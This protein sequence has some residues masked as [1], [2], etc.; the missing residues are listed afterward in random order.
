[1]TEKLDLSLP[2]S[3]KH[4]VCCILK[5]RQQMQ[6]YT[7]EEVSCTDVPGMKA[8]VAVQSSPFQIEV[9]RSRRWGY[10]GKK[11]YRVRL[12]VLNEQGVTISWVRFVENLH[13]VRQ[14]FNIPEDSAVWHIRFSSEEETPVSTW[15]PFLF[16]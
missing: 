16:F 12:R 13:V 3:E 10:F 6:Y 11:G 1:M 2:M 14:S 9:R 5:G 4:L 8:I 15:T 7:T